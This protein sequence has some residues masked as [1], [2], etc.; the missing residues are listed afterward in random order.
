MPHGMW[1]LPGPEIE[2]V[3]PALAGGILTTGPSGKSSWLHLKQI[4]S[5]LSSG[6]DPEFLVL[7]RHGLSQGGN[8][9][10]RWRLG[11]PPSLGLSLL[12][13]NPVFLLKPISLPFHSLSFHFIYGFLCCAKACKF[14]Y[15]PFVYFYFYCLERLT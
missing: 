4:H 11:L 14:Y 10:E 12:F 6:S 2:P 8:P 13:L 5:Q 7:P 3:S 9:E 15:I 1:D